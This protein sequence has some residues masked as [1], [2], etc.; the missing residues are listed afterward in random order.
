MVPLDYQTAGQIRDDDLFTCL[1]GSFPRG[2]TV[3]CIMDCCHSG[4]VLDLP[5]IFKGDGEATSM[6]TPD[7]FDFGPLLGLAAAL[8][9]GGAAAGAGNSTNSPMDD[10]TAQALAQCGCKIL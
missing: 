7:G 6:A 5:F 2:A 8:A 3:T 4:T 1:V 9:A 10:L